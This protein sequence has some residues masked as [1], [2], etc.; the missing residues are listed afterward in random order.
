MN[1]PMIGT[2]SIEVKAVNPFT[3][4]GDLYYELHAVKTDDPEAKVF[5]LKVPQHAAAEIP[6]VGQRFTVT[7]L[8]GQVTQ[9]K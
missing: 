2:W 3:I 7:F 4:H 9:V 6:Q 5:A 1:A 8:M